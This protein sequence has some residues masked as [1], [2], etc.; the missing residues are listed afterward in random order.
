[1]ERATSGSPERS[2][3]APPAGDGAAGRPVRPRAYEAMTEAHPELVCAYEA[4]VAAC[5]TAGPLDERAVALV[6]LAT[7]LAAGLEG[8]T[9]SH[10][11]KA[12]VAGCT[13]EQIEHVAKLQGPTIG[14][15]GMMRGL[16]W[17]RSVTR[18]SG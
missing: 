10:A 17:V 12:L 4:F 1:M 14:F 3:D 2:M 15:P 8:A 5:A 16:G 18:P 7:S 6:K 13:A 11:R 9:R